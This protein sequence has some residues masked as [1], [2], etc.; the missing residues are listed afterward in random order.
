MHKNKHLKLLSVMLILIMIF[1]SVNFSPFYVKADDTV[2][3]SVQNKAYIDVLL[4][5]GKTQANT[6]SFETDLKA[7]L[8]KLGV[9]TTYVNFI[10]NDS[11]TMDAKSGFSA[12]TWNHVKTA[13]TY[14]YELVTHH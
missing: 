1:T 3:V 11:V 5:R 14:Y 2:V 13:G 8:V 6:D 12:Y 9:D 10:K 7:A 4:S